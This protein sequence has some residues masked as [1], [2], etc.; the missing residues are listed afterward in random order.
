MGPATGV[1]L[2]EVR[3]DCVLV[4]RSGATQEIRLP[5]KPAAEGVVKVPN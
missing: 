1:T 2:A 5:A 3:A 4:S